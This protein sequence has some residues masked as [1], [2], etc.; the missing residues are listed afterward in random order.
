MEEKS[1]RDY[2]TDFKA[3]EKKKSQQHRKIEKK[4][5]TPEGSR[6]RNI[7]VVTHIHVNESTSIVNERKMQILKINP[8]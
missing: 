5:K 4:K 7:H 2:Q 8:Y 6:G 1:S 3:C